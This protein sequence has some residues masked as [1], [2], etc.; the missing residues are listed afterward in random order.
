MRVQYLHKLLIDLSQHF[1]TIP[2]ILL[3]CVILPEIMESSNCYLYQSTIKVKSLC[4]TIFWQTI[5]QRIFRYMQAEDTHLKITKYIHF[6]GVFQTQLNISDQAFLKKQ[7][8]I[9]ICLL[10]SQKKGPLQIFDWVV[11]TRLHMYK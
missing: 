3:A 6:R 11:N 9:F 5:T 7:L 10:F 2:L 1:N 8:T 4:Y